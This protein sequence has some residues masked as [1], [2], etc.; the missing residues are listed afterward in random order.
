MTER[1][2]FLAV[3]DLPDSGAREAY[4]K[5]ACGGD[6]N[7]RARVEA[8]LR[9]HAEA[10]SFLA[11]PAVAPALPDRS[12]TEAF[13]VTPEADSTPP[14]GGPARPEAEAPIIPPPPPRPD[15]P[16]TPRPYGAV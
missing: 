16:G 10:G 6:A 1:D 3:L 8:L 2:I 12:A 7:R 5:S 15:A 11:Q 9:S 13:P 14:A 4:L